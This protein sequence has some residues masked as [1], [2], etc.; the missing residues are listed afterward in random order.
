MSKTHETDDSGPLGP[1][2]APEPIG[3][4][5]RFELLEE[6]AAGGMGSIFRARDPEEENRLVAVKRMLPQLTLD[7]AF[8]G[9]FMDEARLASQLKHENVCRVFELGQEDDSY[10][11]A[12]EWVEGASLAELI[13]ERGADIPL[14]IVARILVDAAQGLAY[15]HA[16]RD[17]HGQLLQVIHRDVS[18]PNIM[19]T[20]DGTAKLLDFGLAKA[21]T[22]AHKTAP[23]MVKGKFAYLAP[24]Q[25]RGEVDHRADIFALGLCL[26]ET[27]VGRKLFNQRTAGETIHAIGRF[28]GV[29]EMHVLRP[30]VPHAL[31]AVLM[32]ACAREPADR[33]AS[34]RDFAVRLQQTVEP[35]ATRD[36]VA[37][38]MKRTFPA[39]AQAHAFHTDRAQSRPAKAPVWP[40]LVAV[41][42][43]AVVGALWA[44]L[45]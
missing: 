35:I 7:P 4:C 31:Q 45:G 30:D 1:L 26:F 29:P 10:F 39:R 9:M 16:L 22:Q 32:R 27:T 12:M 25:L 23:G 6:V 40:W 13:D 44:V 36:E 15:A 20:M 24:E 41:G 33:F 2:D 43:A 38:F 11:L 34:A 21:R 5:G 3:T 19:V 42:A 14:A 8:I 37:E 28:S 18:P 17:A